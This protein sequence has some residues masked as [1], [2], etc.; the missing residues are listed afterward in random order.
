M[1]I[2]WITNIPM[3]EA[4]CLM[5]SKSTPLGGWMVGA[6]REMSFVKEIDLSIAFPLNE[7]NT[8]SVCYGERIRYY[9]FPPEK[10][11]RFRRR[12]DSR[13]SSAFKRIL[14]TEH[15]NLVVI[16]GTEYP[17]SL[18]IAKLCRLRGIPA[19]ISIQGL[20]S[21]CALHYTT[22]I[23]IRVQLSYTLR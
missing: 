15:P 4:S 22:G 1:K 12:G 2:L 14:E 5:K 18:T 6:A 21:I 10:D 13:C 9:A 19:T 20:V 23:P 8:L 7:V 16:F 11:Q 17:H 3:P